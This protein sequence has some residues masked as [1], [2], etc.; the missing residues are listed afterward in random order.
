MIDPLADLLER[1]G[2]RGVLDAVSQEGDEAWLVGGCVRN[3]LLNEPVA[4]LDIATQATPGEVVERAQAAG[5]KAIATGLEHGTIT[6]VADGTPFEVTTLRKDVETDGRRA[7]VAF[8]RD[9]A[10]DAARRDFTM[11]ALYVDR[12]AQLVDP[13]GGLEDL[14]AR[15]LRLIG[16]APTRIAED[17]L[18]ILRFFRFFAWY[19]R[20]A[21]DRDA[22]RAIVGGKSGLADLSAERVWAELKRLLSAPD[23]TRALLW[24]RQTS[25]YQAVLPESGDMDLFARFM[26]LEAALDLE[27]DPMLRLQALLPRAGKEAMDALSARL[28]LSGAEST[29]LA[30][31][32]QA[33]QSTD[34]VAI[35]EQGDARRALY[36]LGLER[37]IDALVIQSALALDADPERDLPDDEIGRVTSLLSLA[38][39]YERPKLPVTGGD[40][41]KRGVP[42]GPQLGVALAM[43]E[44]AWVQSDF[45]LSRDELL[46]VLK[47]QT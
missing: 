33:R 7:V 23:P 24:M 9:L 5:F 30:D 37:F 21:P 22:V 47:P 3:A 18:R 42:Q 46:A 14:E 17:Y 35:S 26:R 25:V 6:V 1:P 31:A 8:S 45:T 4:D 13:L 15:R 19:G 29:R 39:A 36:E 10:D 32:A 40:L 12:R 43:M 2:A 41:L 16:D 38:N 11:N 27:A 20:G 44:G 34:T 28:K